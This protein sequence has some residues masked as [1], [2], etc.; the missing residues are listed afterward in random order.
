MLTTCLLAV[1]LSG[2]PYKPAFA[3]P[4][5]PYLMDPGTSYLQL[6][7]WFEEAGG[8]TWQTSGDVMLYYG[9][10]PRHNV[11]LGLPGYS[12]A[13]G[14]WRA[15]GFC[16]LLVGW[17]T[18]L[19]EPAD[20]RPWSPTVGLVAD[21]LVPVSDDLSLGVRP[22][23]QLLSAWDPTDR[24]SLQAGLDFSLP[25]EEGVRYGQWGGSLG[26]SYGVTDKL[27]LTAEWYGLFPGALGEHAQHYLIA[28]FGAAVSDGVDLQVNAGLALNGVNGFQAS[29]YLGWSF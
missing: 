16:D 27:G 12:C 13:R 29:A 21:L 14:A 20:D 8:D 18:T 24:L 2:D 9:A 6:G 25:R 4:D 17:Q 19:A 26:V 7:Y 3:W 15:D 5:S 23:F 11:R 28:G 22:R 1:I 10:A